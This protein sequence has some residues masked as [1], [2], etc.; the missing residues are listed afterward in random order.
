MAVTNDGVGNYFSGDNA[1][2]LIQVDL[3]T[4]IASALTTLGLTFNRGTSNGTCVFSGRFT[5]D[6]LTGALGT[7]PTAPLLATTNVID[8]ARWMINAGS[9]VSSTA[10][11]TPFVLNNSTTNTEVTCRGI[12]T[13]V[14]PTNWNNNLFS[15]SVGWA[16]VNNKSLTCF[17]FRDQNNYAL[18]SVGEFSNI[19]IY[20][21]P[22][23]IY[24]LFSGRYLGTKYSDFQSVDLNNTVGK[25]LLF[26]GDNANYIHTP[27]SGDPAP[28]AAFVGRRADNNYGIGNV[29]NIVKVKATET[30]TVGQ[31]PIDLSNITQSN[32]DI[33]G[34]TNNSFM[35]VGRLDSSAS[36][37]DLGDY[38][39]MR[40]KKL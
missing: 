6:D 16:V 27:A 8:Q 28:A 15:A 18:I 38:L 39:L 12:N 33:L 40:I 4:D 9:G 24:G 11:Y 1:N 29:P 20:T 32:L 34:S 37:D 13:A 21:H 3:Q 23:S 10:S 19:G 36:G 25:T 7:A 22:Q 35:C 2:G 5:D 26:S 30:L 14:S 17:Y 31:F